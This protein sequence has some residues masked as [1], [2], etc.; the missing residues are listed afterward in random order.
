[1]PNRSTPAMGQCNGCNDKSGNEDTQHCLPDSNTQSGYQ[2]GRLP[3]SNRK[4]LNVPE[5]KEVQM[6]PCS[7][8]WRKLLNLWTGIVVG[9]SLTEDVEAM[10]DES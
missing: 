7:P 4:C 3:R 5:G 6:A 9:E 10:F 2:S 8:T 1:M